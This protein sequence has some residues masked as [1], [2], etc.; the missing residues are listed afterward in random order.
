MAN[1]TQ[2]VEAAEDK[3]TPEALLKLSDAELMQLLGMDKTLNEVKTAMQEASKLTGKAREY[4]LE[5][6]DRMFTPN[7]YPHDFKYMV[8]DAKRK[9]ATGKDAKQDCCCTSVLD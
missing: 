8:E 1:E 2:A 7:V 6:L 5:R 4:I 3:P 9:N